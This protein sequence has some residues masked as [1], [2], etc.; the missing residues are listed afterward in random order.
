MIPVRSSQHLRRILAHLR[1]T[2]GM[3][4]RALAERL[5]VTP[6]T[7]ANRERGNHKW[8]T[9]S[10]VDVGHLFGYDLVLMPQR[11]PYRRHTGTG[12]PA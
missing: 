2:N 7:I 12:W 8:D 6:T 1:E 5:F 3:T 11:P 9:D 10:I 4:R